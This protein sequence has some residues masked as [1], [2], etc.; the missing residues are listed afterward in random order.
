VLVQPLDHHPPH[1]IDRHAQQRPDQ[2]RA[3]RLALCKAIG[4]VPS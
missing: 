2:R 4:E 3:Q 1:G